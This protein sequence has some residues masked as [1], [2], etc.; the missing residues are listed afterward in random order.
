MPRGHRLPD[1]IK[2]LPPDVVPISE[3]NYQAAVSALARMIGQ[4][5]ESEHRG[6]DQPDNEDKPQPTS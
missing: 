2:V 3:E 4:W 1:K 5:W 6:K